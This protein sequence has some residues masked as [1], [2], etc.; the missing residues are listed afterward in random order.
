MKS[1]AEAAA[2]VLAK[3]IDVAA[4][5]NEGGGVLLRRLEG[6]YAERTLLILAL[7]ALF[8]S[9]LKKAPVRGMPREFETAV[10]VDTPAGQMSWHIHED[11]L[12]AF[13]HLPPYP[14]GWDGH[15]TSEKYRRLLDPAFAETE[16]RKALSFYANGFEMAGQD[17]NVAPEPT[18]ALIE[19]AGQIAHRALVQRLR[20]QPEPGCLGHEASQG[21]GGETSSSPFGSS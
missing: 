20:Y 19:D 14:G 8:P 17:D 6:A 21:P 18:D 13:A 3:V 7:C 10:Y 12:P 5:P 2:G 11:D 1:K 15:S 9:G 4:P 16:E